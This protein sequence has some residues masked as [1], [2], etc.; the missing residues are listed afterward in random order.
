MI[1]MVLVVV[2]VLVV[3][4]MVMV[5][6]VGTVI[7]AMMGFTMMVSVNDSSDRSTGTD[8]GTGPG[9]KRTTLIQHYGV[10]ST[11]VIPS[12]II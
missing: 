10:T 5:I 3:M 12:R 8:L 6:L 7:V 2:V 4:V 9:E 11:L 1:V